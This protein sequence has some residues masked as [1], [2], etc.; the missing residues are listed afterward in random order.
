MEPKKVTP[1]RLMQFW[2]SF[3]PP[4]ML[5]AAVQLRV[6][7]VLDAG[8]KTV[9]QLAAATGASPRGLRALL[10]GLVGLELLAKQ[11]DAYALTPESAA[12]LVS[13]KPGFRGGIYRHAS[14]QMI[15]SWLRLTEAVRTG[16]PA[17]AVNQEATGGEF[18]QQFV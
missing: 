1:E 13:T 5:E 4:L 14:R 6:F 3:A 7:D 17:L 8:P 9:E 2:F 15:P 10:N 16:K 18:F 12:F 11:G